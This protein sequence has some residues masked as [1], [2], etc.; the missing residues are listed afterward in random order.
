M[1]PDLRQLHRHGLKVE[2]FVRHRSSRYIP[3]AT[4]SRPLAISSVSTTWT[5]DFFPFRELRNRRNWFAKS[6]PLRTVTFETSET[7]QIDTQQ[8]VRVES[9]LDRARL[10]GIGDVGAFS[11]LSKIRASQSI[12]DGVLKKLYDLATFPAASRASLVERLEQFI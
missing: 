2:N 12:L 4:S 1:S 9:L 3:G 5:P 6:A 7:L 10:R 8:S 11:A